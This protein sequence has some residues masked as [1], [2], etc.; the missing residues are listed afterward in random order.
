M[1]TNEENRKDPTTGLEEEAMSIRAP[2]DILN[3]WL[4]PMFPKREGGHLAAREIASLRTQLA[5][6]QKRIGELEGARDGTAYTFKKLT[7]ANAQLVE[8]AE[9]AERTL[10]ALTGKECVEAAAYCRPLIAERKR[11]ETLQRERDELQAQ[12][13]RDRR[14][15]NLKDAA[16]HPLVDRMLTGDLAVPDSEKELLNAA[17]AETEM[18]AAADLSVA[19]RTLAA[20]T[21][22]E[23]VSAAVRRQMDL[24]V[25]VAWCAK[26]S[27]GVGEI[28]QALEREGLQAARAKAKELAG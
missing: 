22:E 12:A 2:E 18:A 1:R 26:H 20:L 17:F 5:E 8:R 23:C 7:E 16:M 9:K 25:N 28:E 24:L 13:A 11:A 4:S 27:R 6:A 19:L 15:L 14:L 10:A 3:E 21:G